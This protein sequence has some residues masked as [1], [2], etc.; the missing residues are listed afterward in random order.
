MDAP[1]NIKEGDSDV[2]FKDDRSILISTQNLLRRKNRERRGSNVNNEI[3]EEL[4]RANWEIFPPIEL[5]DY[6]GDV[7]LSP[8]PNHI[9]RD[10]SS[11]EDGESPILYSASSIQGSVLSLLKADEPDDLDYLTYGMT[12]EEALDRMQNTGRSK[13]PLFFSEDDQASIIGSVTIS[14]LA[15]GI[16]A[17]QSK[18]VEMAQTQVPIF[19]TESKLSDCIPSILQNGFIY[20]SDTNG[21]IVQIYTLVD[22][23]KHLHSTSEMF[24]RVQEIENL[25]R[26]I[27]SQTDE[28]N[29]KQ[30]LSATK[31]LTDI[32]RADGS[33]PLFTSADISYGRSNDSEPYVEKLMFSDYMKCFSSD[34]VWNHCFSSIEGLDRD[35][36]LTSLNDARLARNRVMHISSDE[37]VETLTPSFECLAVWLRRAAPKEEQE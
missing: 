25:I 8:V 13:M 35:K 31:N 6:Y 4:A 33:G 37:I 23:A 3:R 22:L 32:N 14:D 11:T 10:P 20:G 5:A 16:A 12:P 24:L 26:K 7:R 21:K 18:L 17:G 19:P 9:D 29:L 34:V 28:E 1:F 27:L 30:A 2:E 36:C 15:F